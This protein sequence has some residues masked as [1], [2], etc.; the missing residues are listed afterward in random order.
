MSDRFGGRL[1][2]VF[3]SDAPED[4]AAVQPLLSQIVVYPLSEFDGKMKTKDWKKSPSFPAPSN[5][6]KGETKWVLPEK[7]FDQLPEAIKGVPPLPGEEAFY[8]ML[9]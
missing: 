3:Q 6:G 1:P 2:G 5:R 9:C 4:K 8:G 7:F